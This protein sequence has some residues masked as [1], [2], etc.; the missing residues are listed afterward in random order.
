MQTWIKEKLNTQK[1]KTKITGANT[2]L[3]KNYL[4]ASKV[5]Y[6]PI[7][8]FN[9]LEYIVIADGERQARIHFKKDEDGK[10]NIYFETVLTIADFL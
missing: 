9:D 1:T 2:N 3:V 5:R 10:G 6:E 7:Y 4:N 8:C